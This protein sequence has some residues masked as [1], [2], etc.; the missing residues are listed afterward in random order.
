[1]LLESEH[2]TG[3]KIIL[4]DYIENDKTKTYFTEKAK[5][6]P[7]LY[8][9][10]P[11]VYILE[12]EILMNIV[13]KIPLFSSYNAFEKEIFHL[14]LIFLFPVHWLCQQLPM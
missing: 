12:G 8:D 5:K 7:I 9:D 13:E 11:D 14:K 1:M 3:E 10:T 2:H 6:P 4:L